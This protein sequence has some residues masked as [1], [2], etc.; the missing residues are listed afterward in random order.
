MNDKDN[1]NNFILD[2]I[3]FPLRMVLGAVAYPFVKKYKVIIACLIIVVITPLLIFY[4]SGFYRINDSQ[5]K[6]KEE[7]TSQVGNV[8]I[9]PDGSKVLNVPYFNQ[10]IELDGNYSPFNGWQMCG[11][12][13][14]TMIVAFYGKITY[15]I[16]S[17]L[18]K[19]MY[20]DRGQRLPNYCPFSIS[21]GAF[22]VTSKG[23]GCLYSATS[24][25]QEY[26]SFYG[27]KARQIGFNFESIKSSIDSGNPVIYSTSF[28]F[29]HIAVVKGYTTDGKII[30]NDPYKNVQDGSY[31][32][33][34]LYF[35]NGKPNTYSYNG[36]NAIYNLNYKVAGRGI[37]PV[38]MMSVSN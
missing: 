14:S 24:G 18:K 25:I 10:Y 11:A 31:M 20:Q 5:S 35:G 37:S 23:A 22:G 3:V 4:F 32:I 16:S 21:S 30:M 13:S 12:A 15:S 26:L 6:G 36:E 27:L 28:P 29:D 8:N 19:Y 33:N 34:G 1:Q 2:T 9:L 7:S 38:F 17:D